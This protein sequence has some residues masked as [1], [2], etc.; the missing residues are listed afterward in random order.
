MTTALQINTNGTYEVI[1]LPKENGYEVIQRIVGGWFDV[2]RGDEV[3]VYVNDEGLLIE[4]MEPNVLA[5]WITERVIF[6]NVLVVGSLNDDGEYDGDDHDVP[7]VYVTVAKMR[8]WETN[9]NEELRQR[10]IDGRDQIMKDPVQV[11][12][13]NADGEWVRG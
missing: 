11:Y 10:V 4:G 1:T 5:T 3:C 6:G 2:V 12:T 9:N 7:E 13:Q 8:A